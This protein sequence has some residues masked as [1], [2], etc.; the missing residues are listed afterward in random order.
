MDSVREVLAGRH[1]DVAENPDWAMGL[2]GSIKTG[3]NSLPEGLDGALLALADMP[4]VQIAT[5][6][7]LKDEFLANDGQK[8]IFPTHDAHQG[9]PVLFPARFF[10]RLLRLEGDRGAKDLLRTY[11]A[12]AVPVPVLSD[13]VLMDCDTSEDYRLILSRVEQQSLQ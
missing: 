2:S 1:V 4:L 7:S 13:E 12:E 10:P 5:L 9:N 11:A 6:K 3:I 8:I